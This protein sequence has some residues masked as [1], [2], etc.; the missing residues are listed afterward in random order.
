MGK[1][2]TVAKI[3]YLGFLLDEMIYKRGKVAVNVNFVI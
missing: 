2:T 3:M 1:V